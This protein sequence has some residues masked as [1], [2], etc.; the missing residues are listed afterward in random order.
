MCIRTL[1]KSQ[2]KTGPSCSYACLP[3]LWP[4]WAISYILTFLSQDATAK[5]SLV[6]FWF[7]ENA[8]SEMLSSGGLLSATSCLRSPTVLDGVDEAAEPNRPD[9]VAV[10]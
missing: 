6:W 1:E 9:M 2:F 3:S 10:E 8:R 5:K 4:F 7:G